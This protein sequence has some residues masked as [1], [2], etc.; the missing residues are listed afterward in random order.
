[1]AIYLVDYE[2]THA[3]PGIGELS[4][5]D[6]VILFYSQKANSLS[7]ELHR[8]LLSC[9]ARVEYRLVEVGGQDALDHQLGT[10]LG[11]LIGSGET[12][13]PLVIVSR[14][15]GFSYIT[16]FWKRERDL[17]VQLLPELQVVTP[18]GAAGSP[19]A[20][21]AVSSDED[22]VAAQ[23]ARLLADE[24][25]QTVQ[26]VGELLRGAK[27]RAALA[28]LNT[29]LNKLLRDSKRTGDLIRAVKPYYPR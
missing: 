15:K 5:N 22:P 27:N 4:E 2:N 6:R 11:Y 13:E 25:P 10:Y 8:Q 1:M 29:R 17:D 26:Q 23:L 3:L 24:P 18:A 19:N 12:A 7:F 20:T 14:D 28:A 16:S 21:E 9:R